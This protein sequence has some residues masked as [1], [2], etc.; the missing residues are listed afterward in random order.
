MNMPATDNSVMKV[1]V[2]EDALDVQLYLGELLKKWGFDVVFAGNGRE[3]CAL[4]ESGAIRLVI[5]D[6]VMPEMSGVELCRQIR[7]APLRHYIYVI[8]LTSR[9]AE[10]D[11]LEGMD[12]GAD[13]FLTKP[14]NAEE[15]HARI[16][17]AQ[18]VLRL[19]RVLEARNRELSHAN[20]ELKKSQDTLHRDLEAAARMQ[21]SMLPAS[22]QAPNLNLESLF[23]PAT[24]VAGDIFSYLKLDGSHLAFYHIDVAGH[25]VRSAMLSFTLG[26]IL[27]SSVE[28]G[29]PVKQADPACPGDV[30]ITSPAVVVAEL[31]RRFQ[32][33]DESTPYF[34]MIYGVLNTATGH[35]RMCQAGHP[36]PLRVTPEGTVARLGSGG[37]PV[38]LLPDIAY[39]DIEFSLQPGD[40]LFCYSDGISE[41][42]DTEQQ[43]FGTERLVNHLLQLRREPL[44]EMLDSLRTRLQEWRDSQPFDDDVS[45]IALEYRPRAQQSG[46]VDVSGY[47]EALQGTE[48]NGP[49]NTN[50]APG[51]IS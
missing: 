50:I 49:Q 4:L 40:R 37:Y 41:C 1:L 9:N 27:S 19:E 24:V 29:S 47:R 33:K 46:R 6:W 11:L 48:L 25:G 35:V 28:E 31:N 23:C 39:E 21:R 30:R 26:K 10:H 32:D 36:N 12:A 45:L 42:M 2:V 16:K 34:T 7:S 20:L 5:S 17:A 18:R 15:L 44:P 14:F 38:G 8:L 43:A 3:A 51:T 22:D 13:D